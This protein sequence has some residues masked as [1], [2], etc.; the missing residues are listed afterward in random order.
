MQTGD[1]VICEGKHL[2]FLKRGGW[3]MAS[4]KNISGIVGIIPLTDDGKLV[5]VEQFRPPV[6]K[7]VI[8]IPAGLAGDVV[9]HENEELLL[10]AQ[11]ELREETGYAAGQWAQAAEGVTSAGMSDELVTLFLATKLTKVCEAT[12]DGSEEITL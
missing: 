1:E 3:E 12:G 10:A 4:R 6:G 11:R 9:G 5:L 7:R 8:E 2:R